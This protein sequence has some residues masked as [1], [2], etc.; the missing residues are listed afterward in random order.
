MM[1]KNDD[2]TSVLINPNAVVTMNYDDTTKRLT[3]HLVDGNKIRISEVSSDDFVCYC[4]KMDD[5]WKR[6]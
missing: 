6:R 3:L 5:Y 4:D 1:F 2:G